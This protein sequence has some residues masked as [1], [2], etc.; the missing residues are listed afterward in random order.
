MKVY[1]VFVANL[2]KQKLPRGEKDPPSA[3]GALLGLSWVLCSGPRV[4]S[5]LHLPGL[6][7]YLPLSH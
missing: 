1:E 2:G 5:L 3:V 4:T 6:S 7:L